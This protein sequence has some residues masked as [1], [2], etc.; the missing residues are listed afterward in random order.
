MKK[1]GLYLLIA[2]L[3]ISQFTLILKIN[4]IESETEYTK[5]QMNNLSNEIR[6]DMNAI[7][8]NVDDMLNRKESLIEIS[9]TDIGTVNGDSL[10]VPITFNLIPKEVS[11]NTIVNLEF[12]GKLFPMDKTDTSFTATVHR[13][14]FS[15]ALPI[16]VIDDNGVK[17][18]MEDKQIGIWDIKSE[19]FPTMYPRLL[20]T[21][22]YGGDTYSRK[23]SLSAEIKEAK[24]DIKFTK[25]ALIVKVD[26][27]T[28][29]EEII[30]NN[31]LYTGYEVDKKISLGDGEICTMLV[32][33][34]DS[35]GLEHHYTVDTWTGGSNMQREPWF[36]DEYIYSSDGKLLWQP[37][38]SKLY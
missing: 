23:G 37:E 15:D 28:I 27:K 5:H 13:S 20:G 30:P 31:V 9:T 8:S 11:E 19:V 22:S 35:L 33:A 29:S 18:T 10:T 38:H 34:T 14:I 2:I 12:D 6:N 21:A 1:N 25:I 17:K 32:I 36:E 3:M 16:I 7:Y 26:D 24:G 4:R